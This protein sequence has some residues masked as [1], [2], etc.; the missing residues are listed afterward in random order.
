M[1]RPNTSFPFFQV[2]FYVCSHVG[3]MFDWEANK[4]QLLQGHVRCSPKIFNS[5][6][7]KMFSRYRRFFP[8]INLYSY[9]NTLLLPPLL[10]LGIFQAFTVN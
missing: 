2:A 7:G 1:H 4:Q 3:M 9:A 8:Q 5:S 10:P 6:F